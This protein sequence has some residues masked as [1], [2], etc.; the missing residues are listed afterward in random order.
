MQIAI[1]GKEMRYLQ[2]MAGNLQLHFRL[3]SRMNNNLI[4]V[5]VA[6]GIFVLVAM[7]IMIFGISLL[8]MTIFKN[9][10]IS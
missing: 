4:M 7:A 6:I 10:W 5:S 3:K 1:V 8:L 9:F 2:K